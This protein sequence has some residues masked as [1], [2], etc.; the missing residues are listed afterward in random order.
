M[1][2]CPFGLNKSQDTPTVTKQR[3]LTDIPSQRSAPARR[4]TSP[5]PIADSCGP[6]TGFQGQEYAEIG[7]VSQFA[8]NEQ[9]CWNESKMGLKGV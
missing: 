1:S 5:T 2:A 6:N 4:D 8:P 7:I 9:M 3:L